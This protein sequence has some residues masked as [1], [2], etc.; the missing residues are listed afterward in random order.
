M[1]VKNELLI[2]VVFGG[3]SLSSFIASVQK[4]FV[5]FVLCA[6]IMFSVLLSDVQSQ[7]RGVVLEPK[8]LTRHLNESEVLGLRGLIE[9]QVLHV[10]RACGPVNDHAKCHSKALPLHV[11]HGHGRCSD[12]VLRDEFVVERICL[13][14]KHRPARNPFRHLR[15]K[16]CHEWGSRQ[17]LSANLTVPQCF[18]RLRHLLYID[19]LAANVVCVFKGILLKAACAEAYGPCLQ[20]MVSTY[21]HYMQRTQEYVY[22]FCRK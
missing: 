12:Q 13:R 11:R 17:G 14:L 8:L 6:Y 18:R 10:D 7:P 4:V 9:R 1:S 2:L 5:F 21:G 15:M 22:F 19:Q 20:C 16:T 3:V